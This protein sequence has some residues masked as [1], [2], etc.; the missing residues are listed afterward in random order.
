MSPGVWMAILRGFIRSEG[1]R[2][3]RRGQTETTTAA[4]MMQG[5]DRRGRG[6]HPW[7]TPSTTTRYTAPLPPD[8]V[9]LL[10]IPKTTPRTTM[11]KRG[12]WWEYISSGYTQWDT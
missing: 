3:S 2:R 12:T 6:P 8:R 10:L 9:L 11:T 4:K 7:R 5:R 1:V